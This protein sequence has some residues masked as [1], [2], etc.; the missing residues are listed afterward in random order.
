MRPVRTVGALNGSRPYLSGDQI[1]YY[2]SG[3]SAGVKVSTAAKMASEYNPARPDQ[4]V[5]YYLA[6]LADLYEKFR[7]FA[8]RA[9]LFAPEEIEN[10]TA[11]AASGQM[12][13]FAIATEE[14][15]E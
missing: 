1:S 9:G 15:P 4:N 5:E 12:E 11:P 14:S 7:P 2:V 10:E 13:L 6:K 8:E 3:R